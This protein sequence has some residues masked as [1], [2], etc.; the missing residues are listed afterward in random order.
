MPITSIAKLPEIILGLLAIFLLTILIGAYSPLVA[1]IYL[2][3]GA[4]CLAV[5][6]MDTGGHNSDGDFFSR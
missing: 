3:G 2:I 5:C 6:G 4:V 1:M